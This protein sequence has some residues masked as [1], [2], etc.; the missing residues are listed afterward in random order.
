MSILG[1]IL[2][3]AP[4]HVTA[5]LEQIDATAGVDLAYNPGDGRLLLVIHD[6]AGVDA[7]HAFAAISIW[8]TVQEAA[9]V[10]E[11][12]LDEDGLPEASQ[13]L[14]EEFPQWHKLLNRAVDKARPPKA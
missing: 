4:Q 12:A 14:L 10:Y 1:V 3:V 6:A 9:I 8:P 5:T 13:E 7:T 11:A 2:Q